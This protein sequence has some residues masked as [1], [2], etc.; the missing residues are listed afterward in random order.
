MKLTDEPRSIKIP[1]EDWK[2]KRDD[3]L[4]LDLG[5]IFEKLKRVFITSPKHR[6][7]ES[8]LFMST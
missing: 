4:T 6:L 7:L 2:M 3:S 8:V 5:N 1:D